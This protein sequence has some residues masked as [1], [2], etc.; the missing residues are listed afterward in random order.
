MEKWRLEHPHDTP[1]YPFTPSP[2]SAHSSAMIGLNGKYT[3]VGKVVSG[4]HL[5]DKIKKASPSQGGA[6]SNPDMIV[7]MQVAA[8]GQ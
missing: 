5:V 2:T 8:D 7:R 4:M 1:P 3:V 6:A